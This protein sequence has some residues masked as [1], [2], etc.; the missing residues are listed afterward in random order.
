V[1]PKLLSLIIVFCTFSLNSSRSL[2]ASEN[3]EEKNKNITELF[4]YVDC[5]FISLID[6]SLK[7]N[8]LEFKDIYYLP[9]SDWGQKIGPLSIGQAL[10]LN[11]NAYQ[12][13]T[14]T[15]FA[16]KIATQLKVNGE[17]AGNIELK[18]RPSSDI[19][20][21]LINII[22]FRA[23][24]AYI[25]P[26]ALLDKVPSWFNPKPKSDHIEII[27]HDINELITV[28]NQIPYLQYLVNLLKEIQF[29]NPDLNSFQLKGLITHFGL[30]P[31]NKTLFILDL[32]YLFE[33]TISC[34]QSLRSD[35]NPYSHDLQ[36]L[37]NKMQCKSFTADLKSSWSE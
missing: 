3:S 15:D 23:D 30:P 14:V 4:S 28:K 1:K 11:Y 31:K 29:F 10:V 18:W 34:K 16:G 37:Q 33:T 21:M 13:P 36:H 24:R 5:A 9:N 2:A 27:W 20:A 12:K 19:L 25:W 35:Y 32:N 6:Y 17:A 26:Q 8:Y 7:T 22:L